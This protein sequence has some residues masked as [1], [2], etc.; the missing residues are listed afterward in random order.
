[1]PNWSEVLNE[2]Q[3]HK[4][5]SPLDAVRRKYLQQLAEYTGRPTIAYYSAWLSSPASYGCHLV[6]DEDKNALMTAVHGVENWGAGLDLILHTPGG[7][8]AAAE[9]LVEYL[10]S[11]FGTNIR[12]IIPQLAMS[13]GTMIACSCQSIVMGK[14]SSLGPID[15]QFGG[16]AA[17]AVIAEFEQAVA[18][19]EANPA[20]AP[21]WQTIIGKYHPTFLGECHRAIKWSEEIATKWLQTGMFKDEPDALNMAKS[22]VSHLS[23]HDARKSHAR[24]LGVEFCRDTVNL[25][26]DCLE[27]DPTFQDLVLTTHHAFMHTFNQAPQLCKIVE[28]ERGVSVIRVTGDS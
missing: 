20:A 4:L 5:V 18:E 1:M 27:D 26:I 7:D 3:S 8:L 21:L 12:A 13:A 24:H 19:I 11:L 2:I 23:D 16:V 6:N 14:Q 17:P 10:R 22:A 28:N 15:P 9:S 25:R